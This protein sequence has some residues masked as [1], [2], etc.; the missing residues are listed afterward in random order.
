MSADV[1]WETPGLEV[2]VRAD[3]RGPVLGRVPVTTADL[4]LAI[5]ELWLCLLQRNPAL[6][7]S[8]VRPRVLPVGVDPG[9]APLSGFAL[10]VD[11]QSGT[12]RREFTPYSL[13]HV[14][15]RA[16]S[17]SQTP[18]ASTPAESGTTLPVHF[19]LRWVERSAA[20]ATVR[21]SISA[22]IQ[23]SACDEPFAYLHVES[24]TF[25]TEEQFAAAATAGQSLP[26]FFTASA[27]S[28]AERYSRRGAVVVPPVESGAALI[29]HLCRCAQR[30]LFL[31][32]VEALPVAEA[33]EAESTLTYSSQSWDRIA[34]VRR[35]RQERWPST[36]LVG[37]SHGHNFD[38]GPPCA[39]CYESQICGRS[40]VC[41][42]DADL[43]WH[44]HVFR[45]CPWAV[46]LIFGSN[47]R[48]EKHSGLFGLED[49]RLRPRRYGVLP[50][51]DVDQWRVVHHSHERNGL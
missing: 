12:V 7:Q 24:S 6:L 22:E 37:Q 47:A 39:S 20:K 43:H 14:V 38:P 42:S 29:G 16:A 18:Y 25:A 44:R 31:M 49:G 2:W 23:V 41:V 8:E 36:M 28:D 27:F 26:V 48:G 46:C 5:D 32:V 34:R 35:V 30:G 15:R 17:P 50:H 13:E 11:D 21:P 45:H 10:T 40:T 19:E 33:T 9:T 3:A 1:Q 4:A 51:F